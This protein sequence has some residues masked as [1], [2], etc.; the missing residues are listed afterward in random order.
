MLAR[1][2]D[3]AFWLQWKP[4]KQLPYLLLEGASPLRRAF[5]FSFSTPL[6]GFTSQAM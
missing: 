3:W 5:F 4:N 6:R 2:P 1:F